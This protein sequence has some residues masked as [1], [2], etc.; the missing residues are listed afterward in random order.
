[1]EVEI[2]EATKNP[3]ELACKAARNDYGADVINEDFDEIMGN[4]GEESL[5][6]GK[7]KLLKKLIDRGHFGVFEHPNMTFAING[8]SRALMAQITRHRHVSFDIMSMRYVEVDEP[9]V[10]EF[11]EIDTANPTGRNAEFSGDTRKELTDD[12]IAEERRRVFEEAIEKSYD[13]YNELIDL[14][15]APEHA[16]FALPIGTKVNIV[17]TLNLRAL[18]HIA[19]MRAQGDAQKEIRDMTEELLERASDWSPFVVDYYREQLQNRKNRLS[20]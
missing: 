20:P 15:V 16:R 4:V 13:S 11:P 18:L 10:R 7:E 9:N 8:V 6:E 5:Q 2:L 14:G 12:E 19:D 1:M 3:E 17:M